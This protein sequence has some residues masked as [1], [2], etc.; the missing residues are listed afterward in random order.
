MSEEAYTRED[1]PACPFCES[2]DTVQ[3]RPDIARCSEPD[4]RCER[5]W[6]ESSEAGGDDGSI[7]IGIDED[8]VNLLGGKRIPDYE[9][10]E[11]GDND[12]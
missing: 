12:E 7:D 10:S 11:A 6:L 4:C 3:V 1:T 9:P 2:D 5:F 8:V